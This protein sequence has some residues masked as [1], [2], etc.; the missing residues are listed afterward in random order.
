[1]PLF[2]AGRPLK[3]WRYVGAYGPELMLCAG[4]ARVGPLRQRWW[5]LAEPSAPLVERTSFCA[6]G[7]DLGLPSNRELAS[8]RLE[9]REAKLDLVVDAA[10]SPEAIEV[11]SPSGPRGWVWT[12]KRVG[13]LARGAVEVHARRR[14]VELET[15]IDDTAGYHERH[16]SWRWCAGVGRGTSGERIGWNL[17]TGV[18][19]SPD[20]SERS[21][22]ID[23]DAREV[24]P[25]E[26]EADLSRLEFAEGGALS[27]KP[28]AV[29]EH[30]T[31]LLLVR[32]SY[33]QPFGE[34]AGEL[35]GGV[36][37]AAGYGV[38]ESHD[39]WW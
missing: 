24:G 35:P 7:L 11:V 20:A 25:V 39:A 1:M 28:W 26:F 18:H 14:H 37:L 23:G 21:V 15:V 6:G 29:R 33:R 36:A 22:W 38:M 31:D 17:V 32:S 30:S 34:F 8:L 10:A 16:T 12:R 4:D 9:T 2:R 27:F 3:R 5:A 19:D 13:A